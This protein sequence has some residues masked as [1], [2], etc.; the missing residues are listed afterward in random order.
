MI[1]CEEPCLPGA[2]PQFLSSLQSWNVRCNSKML[3]EIN[4]SKESA[5]FSIGNSFRWGCLV[6]RLPT[7]M[8]ARQSF[9]FR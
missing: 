3:R 5:S 2:V 1:D 4:I 6:P 7:R 8:F 9:Q